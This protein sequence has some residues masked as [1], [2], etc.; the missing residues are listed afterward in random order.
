MEEKC[1]PIEGIVEEAEVVIHRGGNS[2][3]K[4]A[5]IIAIAQRFIHFKIA[6]YGAARTFAR[7]LNY[8]AM[9]PLQRAL[10]DEGEKNKAITRLA[11]RGNVYKWH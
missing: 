10:N 1:R 4:D 6:V 5:A 9:D 3:V 2:A 11:R 8:K 7:H